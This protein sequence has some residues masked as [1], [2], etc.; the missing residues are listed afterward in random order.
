MKEAGIYSNVDID[1]YHS[2]E[3]ISSTGIGLI[4]DCPRRYWHE[5]I[6]APN[7]N[8]KDMKKQNDKFKLGRAVHMLIL[9][10]KK[11]HDMF[12]AMENEVNL[13]TKVG[14]EA[15]AQAESQAMGREIIRAKEWKDIK[16]MSEA[17][18]SHPIWTLFGKGNVE[19][20]IYWDDSTHKVRL[21]SRPD[22]YNDRIIVDVKTTDSIQGFKRSLA[23][24]GYHRQAAMQI[25]AL[26]HFEPEKKRHFAFFVVEKKAPYLTAVFTLDEPAI[27]EGRREYL[28]GAYQYSICSRTNEW[29]GYDTQIQMLSLP[30]WHNNKEEIF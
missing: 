10:P 20:S 11:F 6:S 29:P 22:F 30:N 12:Y 4:L 1:E 24:Y 26:A 18:I 16:E 27:Q 17:A 15:Y 8:N 25:D 7:M 13:T 19:H 5:Y 23:Q 14:K 21:R 3:G 28:D 9:E 2:E